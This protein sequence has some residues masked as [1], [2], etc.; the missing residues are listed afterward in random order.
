MRKGI[1]FTVTVSDQKRLERIIKSP[2]SLQK[3]VWRARIIVL[4][5]AGHGTHAVMRMTGKSKTC[6]WRWQDR[7]MV[8]GIEGLLQ[9]KT[10]PPGIAPIEQ[11]R[12][13]Q[14]VALTLKP[15]PHEATHWTLRAMAAVADVAASTVQA[16]WKAHGLAPHR[17]RQFKLS[18]DPAFVEKL[19]DIV[20]LYVS[21]PAHA[22]VLSIDEKSQI[23]A[24]DRTQPGLPLKKGRGA[25][26]TH[27]YKRNGT[28][29]LFAALNV[30]DGTVIGQNMQRH[31]HQE[32]IRFL[33]QIER[34]VPK[35]K[36]I[37]AI[38]DNYAAHKKDKVQAWLQRHPRWTFHFTP[39]SSSWL[40]AVEGFF[41]KLT[42]RRLKHGV[43]YTL[44][45]L[46]AA[47]N[48][49][50]TEHNEKEAKPFIWKADP[51]KIIEARNRGF[52]TLESIH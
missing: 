32:F 47:I 21:P 1:S 46:Q 36:E 2:Q 39:T 26:M 48:R 5:S 42:R 33:N 29:T 37:H 38:V 40:N 6:I 35:D 11:H 8:E 28:T 52:Q 13:E 19:H 20:G 44:V 15:P 27:D 4:T 10:R 51:N 45:E 30:L 31:R 41:A 16:I 3:H 24:L 34:S 7:F 9:D 12:V 23:Q 25:T 17:F 43:F 14:I 18:N 49:F 50:I 22:V